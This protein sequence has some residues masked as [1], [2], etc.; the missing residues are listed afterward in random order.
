MIREEVGTS[1]EEMIDSG[2][3]LHG[4][5]GLYCGACPLS[6]SNTRWS[7]RDADRTGPLATRDLCQE[8]L[9][10][11]P[12][13]ALYHDER[14]LAQTPNDEDCPEDGWW[15]PEGKDGRLDDCSHVMRLP[16]ACFDDELSQ[17]VCRHTSKSLLGNGIESVDRRKSIFPS[18]DM[19]VV[20]VEPSAPLPCLWPEIPGIW[21]DPA[22]RKE[23]ICPD[24]DSLKCS[25]E[26][27]VKKHK[28]SSRICCHDRKRTPFIR[29]GRKSVYFLCSTGPLCELRGPVV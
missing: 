18:V 26:K 11:R 17:V 3:L 2:F 27:D 15:I 21:V 6:R 19:K 5:C 10:P 25:V 9:K 23:A 1:A 8:F 20:L 14:K 12:V 4:Y 28:T 22:R 13:V 24:A 16:T 7:G 29:R